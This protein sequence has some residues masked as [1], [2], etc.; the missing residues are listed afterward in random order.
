MPNLRRAIA[1]VGA[2]LTLMTAA[3]LSHNHFF[4][5]LVHV[6]AGLLWTGTDIFMGFILGPIL[7][8][9]DLG[10]RRAVTE[11]LVPRLL[12]YMPTV[13]TVTTTAG[14]FLALDLG[15]A[16]PSYPG[17]IYFIA[18]LAITSVLFVQG[19]GILLPT[20]LRVF[21]E[22]RKEAPDGAKI[23]R[24]MARYVRVVAVQGAMQVVI[25]AIMARFVA[26][27]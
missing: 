6:F 11:R 25:I 23:Q 16:S 1:G 27:P 17:R 26:G 14:W 12:F 3:I 24:L 21:F 2:A 7:R 22:M 9:L 19:F 5:N 20:N 15:V 10:V 18:A 4:L 13:A 8:R